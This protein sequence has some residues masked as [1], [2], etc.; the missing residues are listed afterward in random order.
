MTPTR[1][2]LLLALGVLAGSIGWAIAV[3]VERH[4]GRVVPVPWLAAV[5]LWFLAIALFVWTLLARPRL[6]RKPGHRRMAPLIAARTAALAMAGSRTGSLVAGFYAGICIGT[7][8]SRAT[9]AGS[10]TLWIS[11]A[12]A[13]GALALAAAALWLEHI[14]RLPTDGDGNNAGLGR[15]SA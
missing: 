12:S 8:P 3:L 15:V 6:K 4:S 9:Q 5:T 1:V 10:D 2:R 14:C 13:A 11:L 7:I